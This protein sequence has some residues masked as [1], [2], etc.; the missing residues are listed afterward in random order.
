[1]PALESPGDCA[2]ADTRDVN[3]ASGIAM[4]TNEA[5]MSMF[6][7]LSV[8]NAIETPVTDLSELTGIHPM[9]ERDT[10]R[11]TFQWNSILARYTEIHPIGLAKMNQLSGAVEALARE[12]NGKER[13][14]SATAMRKDLPK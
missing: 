12:R 4:K 7:G 11:E 1:M 10:A 5:G 14:Y 13:V 8:Q 2:E 6:F 3:R 9:R